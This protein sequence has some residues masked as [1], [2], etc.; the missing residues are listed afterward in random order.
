[1]EENTAVSEEVHRV[2]LH[3]F[4]EFGS[5][6]LFDKYVVAPTISAEANE[7]QKDFEDAGL[8]GCIGSM[9]A[10]HVSMLKW[11]A[12]LKNLHDSLDL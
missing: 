12:K 4:I 8:P 10:T 6:A 3:A 9:D 7:I 11:L 2:F 5:T 1:M